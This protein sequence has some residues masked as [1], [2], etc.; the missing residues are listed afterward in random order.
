MDSQNVPTQMDDLN[1]DFKLKFG[2]YTSL[3]ILYLSNES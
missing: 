1:V 2:N 3:N